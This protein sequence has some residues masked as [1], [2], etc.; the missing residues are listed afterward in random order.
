M[1]VNAL[2]DRLKAHLV[3]RWLI[4][5]FFD[6][7]GPHYAP[8]IAF[9]A[10][11]AIFPMTLGLL[12]L[13]FVINPG[14]DI[15]HRVDA[16][17]I[18]L[19]PASTQAEIRAVVVGGISRHARTVG[20]LSLVAMVWAGSALFACLGAALNALHGTLGRHVVRQRLMGLRLVA[21]ML[22]TLWVLIVLQNLIEALPLSLLFTVAI[23]VVLLSAL[24]TF[25]YRV[26][27]NRHLP[28]RDALPGA[29]IAA[30]LIELVTLLFPIYNR[31][32]D[33]IGSYGR[34]LTLA[35]ALLTWL[36]L[37]SHMVLLGAHFNDKRLEARLDELEEELFSE[38]K[39]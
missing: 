32:V 12:S 2:V 27:P 24:L 28:L 3:G 7:P 20:L 18:E 25:V 9:N 4:T 15:T 10:F 6:S 39:Y 34:G 23:A 37:V 33:Q 8:A 11:I 5:Y 35:L 31:L 14:T 21:V 19:F 17:I 38:V 22:L 16:A 36:Y 29:V 26:A 30:L 13:L 1:P